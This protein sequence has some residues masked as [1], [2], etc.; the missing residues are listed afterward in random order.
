MT[1]S[2]IHNNVLQEM[3]ARIVELEKAYKQLRN[4]PTVTLPI[5]SEDNL[6][7]EPGEGEVVIGEV[8]GKIY[9]FHNG[10]WSV[11]ASGELI[12]VQTTP[13]KL[14]VLTGE[15]RSYMKSAG[16]I[17]LVH[18]SVGVPSEGADVQVDLLKNEAVIGS[19]SIPAGEN[20]ATFVPDEPTY[21]PGDYFTT[22]ITAVGSPGTTG[23]SLVTKLF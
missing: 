20:E 11:I 13:G 16:T 3:K 18:L 2:K 9:K 15:A 5:T 4:S 19:G 7:P 1:S 22:D 8:D 12:D 6:P 14:R 10:E 23:R 21:E 17:S